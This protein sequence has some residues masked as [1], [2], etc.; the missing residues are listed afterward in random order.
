M[1]IQG[2][3]NRIKCFYAVFFTAILVVFLA[4]V[5]SIWFYTV[6]DAY[7]SFRYVDNFVHGDGLTYNPGDRVE[8]YT[9][10]LWVILLSIFRPFI[11]FPALA[12]KIGFSFGLVTLML[13]FFI[14][15]SRKQQRWIGPASAFILACSPGFQLW[16]SAGLETSFFIFWLVLGIFIDVRNFK[17]RSELCGF[18]FGLAVFTRP[19]GVLFFAGFLI[20]KYFQDRQNSIKLLG[21]LI[22]FFACVIPL[23]MFRLMYYHAWV[24]NTFW[25]KGKR[26]QGGGYAYFKRYLI[27]TG[28]IILPIAA[29]GIWFCRKSWN[30]YSYFFPAII[31]LIYVYYIGGDWM[32]MGR[33]LI[34]SLPFLAIASMQTLDQLQ[35]RSKKIVIGVIVL[36]NGFFSMISF[37]YDVIRGVESHFLDVLKWESHFHEDWKEVGLWMR[38]QFPASTV[39]ST[40]LAGILPYYSGLKNI[41]RSGLNN[42]QIAQI[43][44]SA[45][46]IQEEQRQID[47]IIL[48]KK[49]EIILDETASF[50]MLRTQPE[51][52]PP[53]PN[54]T[55][56]VN[57]DFLTLYEIRTVSISGRYFSY[58]QLRSSDLKRNLKGQ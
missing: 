30:F 55:M 52:F 29:S 3:S 48:R 24:P 31:Y 44:H 46:D 25:V 37:N 2:K 7:I 8:G 42:S 27:L 17:F 12:K 5:V 57:P 51:T 47:R 13:L 11:E 23:Q 6:E 40:G 28:A 39:I 10:F 54:W 56:G 36:I 14:F 1:I 19:D 45:A 18:C 9:D 16:S 33:F 4:G 26:F 15:W 50:V 58:Y 21:Y 53:D 49:P 34:P 35:F 32:P 20:A 41:D 38:K 43:I 22:G